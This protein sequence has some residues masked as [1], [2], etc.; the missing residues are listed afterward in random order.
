M[1]TEQMQSILKYYGNDNFIQ[2]LMSGEYNIISVFG[3]NS[4]LYII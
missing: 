1:E 2:F 4:L 3:T